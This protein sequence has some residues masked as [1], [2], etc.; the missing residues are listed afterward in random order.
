MIAHEQQVLAQEQQVLAH[1]HQVIAHEQQVLTHEQQVLAHEPQVLAH[2]QKR[3]GHAQKRSA[4]ATVNCMNQQ[5]VLCGSVRTVGARN[6]RTEKIQNICTWQLALELYV[7][8]NF[9]LRVKRQVA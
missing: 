6:K 2:A 7:W 8:L 1:E 3:V 4:Y 5:T 9:I